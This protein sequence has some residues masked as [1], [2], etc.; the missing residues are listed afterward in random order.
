MDLAPL[1]V[2]N[3]MYTVRRTLEDSSPFDFK[4]LGE[5]SDDGQEV[6]IREFFPSPLIRRKSGKTSVSAKGTNQQAAFDDGLDYFA[7]E[8]RAL[9]QL[10]HQALPQDYDVFEANG[11]MYRVRNQHPSMSLAEGLRSKGTLP[12]KAA[13]TIMMPVL[14]A[15][16]E[17]HEAGLYHGGISPD[18][19]RLLPDGNVLVTGFR[20]AYLQLA[21][22]LDVLDDFIH[23]STSAI[24]Q[25]TPRAEQGPAT[26]VYAAAATIC[27]MVTGTELPTAKDRLSDDQAD[28]MELLVQDAD[29]FTSPEVRDVL[30]D[31]LRVD[32][33]KRLQSAHDLHTT[34]EQASERYDSEDDAYVVV[35]VED[36]Q[37]PAEANVISEGPSDDQGTNPLLIAIPVLLLI[38][39]V[40]WFMMSGSS[41]GPCEGFA[42]TSINQARTCYTDAE[43]DGPV[44]VTLSGT[45]T[46]AYSDYVRLQD[47][48]GDI[49]AS[50]L[51][52]RRTTG[53]FHDA[54]GAGDI[55]PGTQLQVAGTLSDFNGLIQI[56]EQDLDSYEITGETDVP[57]P[58]SIDLPTVASE[59]LAYE[60]VL[61]RV[62][63]LQIQGDATTFEEQ[64]DYVVER[65]GRTAAFRV[66]RP[67]ET[68]L[69]GTAV[70]QAPFTYEGVVG[71]FS[72]E[73]QLIPIRTS[74]LQV[75]E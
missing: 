71:Q 12:E 31:A 50:G 6:I 52:V 16:H 30:L 55:T 39:G 22:D 74:D 3:G 65:D 64:S 13:L 68:E 15:L 26:D 2:L 70:P 72:G 57:E 42:T 18:T 59:G 48:S 40:V 17:A 46:R 19:I 43:N 1:T 35:P 33:S 25:Y 29:A 45:V 63:S 61:I 54:I 75:Q 34:L 66:Q 62:D 24:E 60:S 51:V 10:S 9:R 32:P 49:G 58:L 5:R 28:P 44:E 73:P 53:P 11:T 14:E 47:E 37:G 8:S 67:S 56:N 4:Y 27:M 23:P 7:K 69:P 41:G 36:D 20:G 21:R 38:G